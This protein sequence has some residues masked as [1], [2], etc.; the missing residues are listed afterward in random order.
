MTTDAPERRR[1]PRFETRNAVTF[2]HLNKEEHYIGLA[3]NI[4]RSGMYFRSSRELKSGSC[5]VILPLDCRATD[6]LWGDGEQGQAA[7]AFCALDNPSEDHHRFFVHMVTAQVVRCDLLD[8]NDKL[9]FGVAV[10]YL[11]PT[12]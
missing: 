2:S 1:D 12:V 6:L 10:D 9:R 4:S 11:R 8:V 7:E 5:I 3:R